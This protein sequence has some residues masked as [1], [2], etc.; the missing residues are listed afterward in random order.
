MQPSA[1]QGLY[2]GLWEHEE[3]I[4]SEGVQK[5]CVE[6]NLWTITQVN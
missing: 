1:E 2:Q 4:L 6:D 3:G 5:G